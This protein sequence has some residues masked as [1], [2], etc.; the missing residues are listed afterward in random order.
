MKIQGSNSETDKYGESL[1]ERLSRIEAIILADGTLIQRFDA[2]QKE[3]QRVGEENK[4]LREV[5]EKQDSTLNELKVE[6]KKL[7]SDNIKLERVCKETFMNII[8][9]EEDENP[10]PF[11]VETRQ[12]VNETTQDNRQMVKNIEGRIEGKYY[13]FSPTIQDTKPI[14]HLMNTDFIPQRHIRQSE[15]E[16]VAFYSTVSVPDLTNLGD[17]HP[18]AFDHVITNIGGAYHP[19]TGLFIAPVDGVYVFNLGG[20][21]RPRKRLHLEFV[22]DG[23]EIQS[24]YPDAGS[25]DSFASDS[26]VAV[27]ELNK[28]SEVWVRTRGGSGE[29]HGYNFTFFTG[30]LLYVK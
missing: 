2:L 23:T 15:V 29:I 17:H 7:Q 22:K 27:L 1:Q 6:I 5:V 30:W 25:T 10:K 18:I 21:S 20:M 14:N 13:D 16:Q 26:L 3:I 8:S 12:Q 4:L 24:I 28:G 11:L 19:S 9:T